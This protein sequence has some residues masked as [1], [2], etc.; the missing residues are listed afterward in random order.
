MNK[1]D[2]NA[3]WRQ[4][5]RAFMDERI[6][7]ERALQAVVYCALTST[8][9]SECLVLVEPGFPSNQEIAG[10][11]PDLL[12]LNRVK[13]LVDCFF[14]IKCAPHFWFTE[15]DIKRDLDK[16]QAYSS[17]VGS[18]IEVDVLGPNRVLDANGA[19]IGGR[20]QYRMAQSTLVAFVVL[21]RKNKMVSRK[22]L[23]HPIAS[24]ANF[25]FLSGCT[26]PGAEEFSVQWRE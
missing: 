21:A 24:Q 6:N 8:L 22:E 3:V 17:L 12:A 10:Y 20:P 23:S 16:L 1:D 5:E 26:E 4:V 7:S 25:V 15:G 18:T 14:E 19:W 9:S 11:V 2:L 13:R